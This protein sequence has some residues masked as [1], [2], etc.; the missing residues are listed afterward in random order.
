TSRDLPPIIGFFGMGSSAKA[1]KAVF[2]RISAD[3]QGLKRCQPGRCQAMRGITRQIEAVMAFLVGA[4]KKAAVLESQFQKTVAE[5]DV[6]LVI[7]LGNAGADGG[8]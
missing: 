4:D 6:H 3:P 8:A 2:R 5:I 7:V 1:E